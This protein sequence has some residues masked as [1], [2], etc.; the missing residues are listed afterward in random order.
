MESKRKSNRLT[1]KDLIFIGIFSAVAL[2]L[3]FITGGIAALTLIGTLANIPITLFFI[4]APF[5]VAASKVRKSGVFLI[6]GTI[7][8][9]PGFMAAN[10]VGVG[11][12]MLGWT[13]AEIIATAMKYKDKKAMILAYTAG[14]TLQS[15]LFTLPMY[16]SHGD[17]LMKRQEILHLTDE[18][19]Q[20]YLQFFTW[21]TYFAVV[22]LTLVTAVAGALISMRILKKHF[23][24]AGM[25]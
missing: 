20:I 9:L 14:S 24:K 5:M 25:M 12:S 13:I 19:L 6:M 23:E 18:A 2:L 1:A 22:A 11:L 16:L 7:I 3:F 8:V 15:A 17:Y 10:A 4:A 21:P